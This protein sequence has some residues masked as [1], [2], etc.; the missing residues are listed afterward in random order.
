[1]EEHPASPEQ[2]DAT[3]ALAR[4]VDSYVDAQTQFFFLYGCGS[5]QHNQLLLAH[6]YRY[7]VNNGE[8]AHTL[9]E[10]L[11]GAP[12]TTSPA[13]DGPVALFAGGGHSALLTQKGRLFLFGWNDM[14]QCGEYYH[15]S[16]TSRQATHPDDDPP[17]RVW[18]FPYPVHACALGF[19]HTLVVDDRGTVWALGD[20]TKGQVSGIC[21]KTS[22]RSFQVPITPTPLQGFAVVA[23]AAGL[24]HSAA[25]TSDGN[26]VTWGGSS[27]SDKDTQT[28]YIW[29]PPQGQKAVGV[30][31]G[32]KFTIAWLEDATI[33]SWGSDNKYGQL[34]RHD[35]GG[36]EEA[37]Q[38]PVPW[39][40][41][42]FQ[43]CDIQTGWSHVVV[44]LENSKTFERSMY[45]W[46]RNDKGQL[47]LGHYDMARQPTRIHC[48]TSPH[49][50]SC[51][52]EFTVAV[53]SDGNLWACG[54]NEHGN[55]GYETSTDE[56][57]CEWQ[58]L[59]HSRLVQP[60]RTTTPCLP[61]TAFPVSVA[62]GGS[63]FLAAR[64]VA[65]IVESG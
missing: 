1:L 11:V 15:Q 22:P 46:G 18:E 47:G 21:G 6:Y 27:A 10:V 35:D 52:S 61:E 64:T 36:S 34:G 49:T 41:A 25:V 4:L 65:R 37:T 51:G 44:L 12:P 63:H 40:T 31:C 39:N 58:P 53:A 7:L 62:A 54:W 32:R 13:P 16:T 2:D 29:T 30:A 55:L 50:M 45:G 48:G 5:N 14:G 19:S 28:S 17:F 20:N 57:S 60:P 23:V 9:T 56:C 24:F 38:V 59:S 26:V 3:L 33:W 8:E 43:I 42:D